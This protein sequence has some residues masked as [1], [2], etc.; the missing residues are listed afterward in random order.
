VTSQA[1]QNAPIIGAPSGP[2]SGSGS[3]QQNSAPTT[4]PGQR[5]GSFDP[6]KEQ[7][8]PTNNAQ[9]NGTQEANHSTADPWANNTTGGD[10]NGQNT[11]GNADWSTNDNN[12]NNAGDSGNTW[13]KPN[14]DAGGSGNGWDQTNNDDNNGNSNDATNDTAWDQN[15]QNQNT[16]WD[17]SGDAQNTSGWDNGGQN[18]NTTNEQP[19]AEWGNAPN[20]DSN[21]N[22]TSIA[23][24]VQTGQRALYGPYGAYYASRALAE[25]SVPHDAEEE[26]RYDVPQALA[27]STGTSKQVQPGK[28]YLYNKKRC[29]PY[30]VDDLDAPYARFVFKYRTQ[31]Q[32]KDEIGVDIGIEPTPNEEANALE[33]LDKAELIQLVLRAKNALG[34]TIPTTPANEATPASANSF[35]P[36]PVDPPEHGFLKY[37]LP[38]ARSASNTKGLGISF[39]GSGPQDAAAG[40]NAQE[41]QAWD[42]SAGN[43]WQTG[44]GEQQ[45][46]GGNNHN[47]QEWNNQSAGGN[48]NGGGWDGQQE[49]ANTSAA[50]AANE[51]SHGGWD[52]PASNQ[53]QGQNDKTQQGSRRGSSKSQGFGGKKGEPANNDSRRSSAISPNGGTW[54]ASSGATSNPVQASSGSQAW[55]TS[56]APQASTGPLA[57]DSFAFSQPPGSIPGSFPPPAPP[58]SAP[59]INFIGEGVI[60]GGGGGVV[61]A[62][63]LGV[64][65][66]AGFSGAGP[67]PPTPTPSM[68][69]VYSPP[70]VEDEPTFGRPENPPCPQWQTQPQP[71][72]QPQTGG[73]GNNTEQP[74]APGGGW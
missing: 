43:N 39:N 16:N 40:G 34:G 7:N 8:N 57:W 50:D 41:G 46:A 24:V 55:D 15:D 23:P 18:N 49:N 17:Q 38:P 62:G 73:W 72:P 33:N 12:T 19:N 11:S 29:V 70:Y 51:S 2:P 60:G 25:S 21:N 5:Q 3:G 26:P 52:K 69:R 37:S 44:G 45:W 47:N 68:V 74:A 6:A 42:S 31:A 66:T 28:G 13:D 54:V 64:D 65:E 63:G 9:G 30:Y 48:N 36:V 67:R 53:S 1:S 32:I 71:P 35:D 59:A 58:P 56:A 4:Q 14:D 27:Q 10:A 20:N 22:N 61:G